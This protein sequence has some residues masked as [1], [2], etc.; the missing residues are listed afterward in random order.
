MKLIFRAGAF[1]SGAVLLG[2]TL[3][4]V[5]LADPTADITGNGSGSTNTITKTSSCTASLTQK[6][7]TKVNTNA[8]V[9]AGTGLNEASGNTGGDVTIDTGDATA[10]ATVTVGGS[11]NEGTLPDCCECAASPS[12]TISENGTKTTNTVVQTDTKNVSATQKNKTRVRTRATVKAKTG[13]NKTNGN[14]NGTVGVTTGVAGA[15]V[16]VT[17]DPSSNNL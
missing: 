7:K 9:I 16:D 6:N 17:V 4:G 8:T 10:S 15:S 12:A 11:S 14:T 5:T 1:V 13:K 2:S 3:V